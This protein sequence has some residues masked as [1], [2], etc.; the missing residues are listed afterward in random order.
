METNSRQTA[1]D[2]INGLF[3]NVG[4]SE[5]IITN[6]LFKTGIDPDTQV[7]DLTEK[8][9]DLAYAY[10]ILF[11]M[12]GSGSSR[13]VTDRDGDWEHSEKVSSWTYADRAGLWRIAKALLEKWGIEDEL[14]NAS[15]PQWGFKGTGFHKIRRYG[16]RR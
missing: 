8:E 4:I 1:I 3:P 9:R 6:I 2:Y 13:S 11:L 12:P 15:S 16:R 5:S 10:L 14:L 7:Y